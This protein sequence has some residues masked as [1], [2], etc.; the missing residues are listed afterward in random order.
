MP[1]ANTVDS[2][3]RLLSAFK[4]ISEVLGPIWSFLLAVLLFGTPL[5][6]LY[7]RSRRTD[8]MWER[9][10]VTKDEMIEKMNEQ[11]RELRVQA[12]VIGKSFTKEEAV[13]LV[14]GENRLDPNGTEGKG[15]K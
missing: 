11:N 5:V 2:Y 10:V 4:N 12:L 13:R 6:V 1:D 3:T 8:R 14:Y 9:I 15:R 7:L